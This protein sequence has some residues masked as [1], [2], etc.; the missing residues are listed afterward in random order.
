MITIEQIKA[1]RALLGWTQE[2]LAQAANLSKPSINTLERRI[3][4][5]KQDTLLAVQ[6]SLEKAGVEFSEGLGVKLKSAVVKTIIFEGEDCLLRLVNDIFDTL[7]GTNKELMICGVEEGKYKIL[8]GQRIVKAVEKRLK[9]NIKSKLIACEGDTNFLEP[10]EHYRW[11][12][13]PYFN[14]SPFYVYDNK[15][16]IFLWG[17][18]APNKV[19]LIENEDIAQSYREYFMQLWTVA[20]VPK[21]NKI[22]RR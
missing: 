11:L 22:K 13:K 20:K 16:A 9:H 10:I 19:V 1:A 18:G 3:S 12:E 6:Q 17:K 21:T 8:G 14:R 2:D 4:N 5:P 7:N 15:Y